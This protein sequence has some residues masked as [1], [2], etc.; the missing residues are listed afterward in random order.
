MIQHNNLKSLFECW[1]NTNEFYALVSVILP[2]SSCQHHFIGIS[3]LVL[4]RLA[5]LLHLLVC[6]I[7]PFSSRASSHLASLAPAYPLRTQ[8]QLVGVTLLALPC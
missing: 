7:S 5:P 1:S 8:H 6:V 3:S 2:V 4:S